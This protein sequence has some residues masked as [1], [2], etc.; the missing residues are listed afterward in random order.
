[1]KTNK[2]MIMTAAV[3]FAV[4][5]VFAAPAAANA[6][7]VTTGIVTDYSGTSLTFSGELLKNGGYEVID[8]GFNYGTSSSRLT[9]CVNFGAMGSEKGTFTA[10]A[11]NLK[12]GTTYYYQA[13][14]VNTYNGNTAS[15]GA[16]EC[17]TTP[18]QL[19][20]IDSV[21]PK[22]ESAYAGTTFSFTVTANKQT[23]KVGVEIDGNKIGTSSDYT[24]KNGQHVFVIECRV[25]SPG[26][27][28]VVTAY[29]YDG[30]K[31]LTTG[32]A[33][34]TITVLESEPAGVPTITKPSANSVYTSGDSVTVKWR[35]PSTSPDYYRILLYDGGG[36]PKSFDKIKSTSYTIPGS[37]FTDA[38]TYSIHVYAFK[39]GYKADDPGIVDITVQSV[40]SP[41]V[42]LTPEIRTPTSSGTYYT[43]EGVAVSWRAPTTNPDSYTVLLYLGGKEVGRFEK[44]TGTSYTIPGSYVTKTGTY[45]IDVYAILGNQQDYDNAVITV[46]TNPSSGISLNVPYYSQ[47]DSKWGSL[48][49]GNGKNTISS[50][51]CLITS[52]AMIHEYTTGTV[53]TPV[54]MNENLAFSTGSGNAQ[55]WSI[56]DLGYFRDVSMRTSNNLAVIP[57]SDDLKK[58]YVPLSEGN[59]VMV[60]VS[61]LSDR[62]TG[63]HFVVVNGYTGDGRSFSASDFTILDPNSTT[64]KT[65]K[66]LLKDKPYVHTYVYSKSSHPVTG[67]VPGDFSITYP[68]NNAVLTSTDDIT[69]VWE[70]SPYALGYQFALRDLTISEYGDEGKLVNNI[71]VGSST[72][73]TIDSKYLVDTHRYHFAVCA[74][75]SYGDLWVESDFSVN[76]ESAPVTVGAP[77]IQTPT[78]SG[79]YYTGED[80]AVSWSAPTTKPDSYTVLLYLGGKEVGRFEK[81]T[82]TSHTIPGSYFT[83][84]GTYS[85]DVYAILGNQ[86]DYDNA[87]IT[88]KTKPSSGSTSLI[89]ADNYYVH[90]SAAIQGDTEREN[91]LAAVMAK[92]ADD[93]NP[94]IPTVYFIEGYGSDITNALSLSSAMCVVVKNNE[95]AFV[96]VD[97]STFPDQPYRPASNRD[98][99]YSGYGTDVPT[100]VSG[101]YTAKY[102]YHP[103]SATQSISYPALNVKNAKVHRIH[104]KSE[105]NGDN[106]CGG[107]SSGSINIHKTYQQYAISANSKY[108]PNSAGCL[109]V[110]LHGTKEYDRFAYVVG[111][112]QNS[113]V[114]D[115]ISYGYTQKGDPK[116][117]AECQVV[118]DRG[119]GYTHNSQFASH[120][121]TKYR[122]NDTAISTIIGENYDY[123]I[124]EEVPVINSVTSDPKTAHAGT[125]FI[126]TVTANALTEKV[127][128][129]IDGNKIGTSSDYTTGT[130]GQRTFVIAHVVTS[131]GNSRVVTA[132]AYDGLTKLTSGSASSTITVLDS[133]PAGV[134]T[135]T[136]P[137][138][139]GVYSPGES[140]TINWTAP[141]TNPEYYRILL[142][143]GEVEPK[144]FD[145]IKGTSYTIPGS[146]LTNVGTYSIH[147]YA[148]KDGYKAD[149]PGIVEIT[150]Q[151]VPSPV[152]SLTPAIQTPDASGK[153]YTGEDVTVSWNAPTTKPDSYTV[154]LYFGGNEVGRSE[155]I[156]GTSYT[157]PGSYFT[158][159]GTYSIDVY[160]VL[161]NQQDCD[162]VEITVQ[163][164]SIPSSPSVGTIAVDTDGQTIS[165]GSKVTLPVVMTN[166]DNLISFNIDVANN[167]P[168]VTITINPTTPSI[169]GMFVPQSSPSNLV[170]KAGWMNTVGL[171][172]DSAVLFYIDVTISDLDAVQGDEIPLI[173][174]A[175]ELYSA[176]GS[177][178]ID[179]YAV[180]QEMLTVSRIIGS[181]TVDT[182]DRSVSSGTTA[183][184]PVVMDNVQNLV[185][186]S[187]EVANDIPGV[188][189]SVNESCKLNG[190]MLTT[191]SHPSNTVQSVGWVGT[192]GL[193]ADT[194]ELFCIDVTI[195]DISAAPF[196]TI[197]ITLQF[198]ELYNNAG[199]N[200]VNCY[201]VHPGTLNVTRII[202]SV[203]V[204][205]ADR[206]VSPG[207]TAVIPV[208]MDNVQ[209][210]LSFNA[211]VANDIP[212]VIIS[213]NESRNPN[214]GLLSINSQPSNTVQSVGWVGT[215]GLTAD[216]AELFYID[217]TISDIS[218][219]T[220]DT[221]P[222]TLQFKELYTNAGFNLVN[223]YDVYPGTLNISRIINLKNTIEDGTWNAAEIAEVGY[224]LSPAAISGIQ[225]PTVTRG[226]L[227]IVLNE[228]VV[229][230]K[231]VNG[232][233]ILVEASVN[234][235]GSV[236][237]IG[238]ISD[239]KMLTVTFVGRCLGD[240]SGDGKANTLD[241]ARVLQAAVGLHVLGDTGV[242]YGDVTGDGVANTLDAARILQFSVGLT[243]ETYIL[244]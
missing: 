88:V 114:K 207:T 188:I 68:S 171:N 96:S 19:M 89:Y 54:Y 3:L 223:C 116:Q 90:S 174:T 91:A 21:T 76:V 218:A 235:D 110:G 167:V 192:G 243:D 31:K 23:E 14:A 99:A 225:A 1:M 141:S 43:G 111:F 58:I 213:I 159:T 85:I 95:I 152:V 108:K 41:V 232:Q 191:N 33:S 59:P 30:S 123:D 130:N 179:S 112:A 164:T 129:E 176:D 50:H 142:Y 185:A 51:G 193:T 196:D 199:S 194:A 44:I 27:N 46:Q 79:K 2:A 17:F 182:A 84:T 35:A 234:Q 32:S 7:T 61:R 62:D 38:G 25:T 37:Y 60:G 136:T 162:N 156:T 206:S 170:Q 134:P 202:G 241:A 172:K 118:V 175:T 145:Y 127:G 53:H 20:E 6:P 209:N 101:I 86:Q 83:K 124:P 42:S 224:S 244:R 184:I 106:K 73:Y 77:T 216:T 165:L 180:Q 126:F 81:I 231:M 135:I 104:V 67:N 72:S 113:Y 205:T 155:K 133:D 132:Y 63:S 139:N 233:E 214:G 228:K 64:R 212:G 137:A 18:E 215:D 200:L 55:W 181:V 78:A 217:V 138:S 8:T 201:E 236:R 222:I 74:Y 226:K 103:D 39:E 125:T 151:T 227:S 82:G 4:C 242:F 211:E 239:A 105:C 75:N 169:G 109:L 70:S 13:Y 144:S 238:D 173:L 198:K 80:V 92:Y 71:D 36:E 157:I 34:S 47:T 11:T 177:N 160:A 45:S 120:M 87:V 15:Y 117:Y 16:V 161:G 10:T 98:G 26:S 237:I 197:P 100:L 168:G 153:Y 65:L 178:L 24:T 150:V 28:R 69:V 143:D 128:V 166:V 66:D 230:M 93:I 56:A 121:N 122:N 210:L 183:V 221:I 148:F 208:V 219:V 102:I 52:L 189:I 204:D 119:Y 22:P 154:L 147:V 48:K 220:S 190:G 94:D 186:F 229:V 195:S 107:T 97:S 203:T 140:V 40:P 146:Y 12:P 240:V 149:E 9:K 131:A 158:K 49:L 29:A 163:T 187:A 5:L 115:G 57:D